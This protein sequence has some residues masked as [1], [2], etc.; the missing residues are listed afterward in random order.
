GF[1]IGADWTVADRNYSDYSISSSAYT[2]GKPIT[3]AD[4]WRIPWGNQ[5]DLNA[6]YR[7]KIGGVDAVLSGNVHNLCN[8]N[9]VVDAYTDATTAG[10]WENAFRVFY[11]FGRTYSM[12]LRVNF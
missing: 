5:L 6:S 1:R 11:S 4:P 9:Y 12:K 8:Y 2:P 3:V 10:T 7:F